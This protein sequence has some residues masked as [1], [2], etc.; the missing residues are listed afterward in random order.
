[1]TPSV[2]AEFDNL[3]ELKFRLFLSKIVQGSEAHLGLSWARES[4]FG[5]RPGWWTNCIG[6]V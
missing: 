3:C 5:L 1:M 2:A 6:M 4:R